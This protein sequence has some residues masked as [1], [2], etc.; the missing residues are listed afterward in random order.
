MAT[1]TVWPPHVEEQ[2]RA[3]E[4]HQS[5]RSNEGKQGPRP[6]ASSV[7]PTL[8]LLIAASFYLL[9]VYKIATSKEPF[10]DEG[11]IASPGYNL[12]FHG[13][14]GTSVLDPHGS[15]LHGELKGIREYTYWIMPLDV[16]AQAAWYRLSGFGIVQVRLLAATFGAL[17][18][19]AWFVI[20]ER[21]MQNPLAASLTVLLTAFD[22]TF[23]WS[24]ADGRMDMMCVA[25]GSAGL[26]VYLYLRERNLGLAIFLGNCLAACSVFTH[27]NGVVWVLLLFVLILVYDRRN[28]KIGYAASVAPYLI[29]AAGWGL[30]ILKHPDYFLAQFDAN[31]HLPTG[32]RGTG[33]LHPIYAVKRELVRYWGHFL[34]GGVW[35]RPVPRFAGLI[36]CLYWVICLLALIHFAIRRQRNLGIIL[37]IF[38][39]CL[40]MMTFGDSLKASYYFGMVM[41]MYAAVAAAWLCAHD[42]RGWALRWGGALIACLLFFQIAVLHKKLSINPLRDDYRPTVAFLKTMPTATVT[43]SSAF[44]FELGYDRLN[45]DARLGMYSGDRPDLVVRDWWY[46][47]LWQRGF[48]GPDIDAFHYVRKTLAS[49]Y[50]PVFK[51][52]DYTVYQLN[53][54]TPPTG[55][56]TGAK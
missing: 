3:S 42:F 56:P 38:G 32:T 44:G 11:W 1:R 4:N 47:E 40:G 37:L 13:F 49:Y 45:D 6:S 21:I 17:A 25:L 55:I 20:V 19:L 12:A 43:A 26:A 30:Y 31:L 51:Q 9:A 22:F 14:M 46:S 27:P 34:W 24:A 50:H 28:L 54:W 52:G 53:S 36:P 2:R 16:L 10:V 5:A 15:W 48:R 23:L 7:L 35:A 8:L 39:I 41:P 33:F 18:L 29:L